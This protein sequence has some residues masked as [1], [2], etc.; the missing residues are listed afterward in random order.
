MKFSCVIAVDQARANCRLSE[1]GESLPIGLAAMHARSPNVG[2]IHHRDSHRWFDKP[3]KIA[4]W[5]CPD[6]SWSLLTA[7]HG[8]LTPPR[9][10]KPRFEILTKPRDITEFQAPLVV[11]VDAVLPLRYGW[12]NFQTRSHGYANNLPVVQGIEL[13]SETLL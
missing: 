8:Y 10:Q 11:A 6:R 7:T 12:F 4:A 1:L 13:R 3:S 2:Q 9:R 5:Q